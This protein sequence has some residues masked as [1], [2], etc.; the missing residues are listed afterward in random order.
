MIYTC[1]GS[2]YWILKHILSSEERVFF[3]QDTISI[4]NR[5][6]LIYLIYWQSSS[7]WN[8]AFEHEDTIFTHFHCPEKF[9]AHFCTES[10]QLESKCLNTIF[11]NCA[12][13]TCLYRDSKE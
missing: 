6:T 2:E 4:F 13:G 5:N 7:K 10:N 3:L 1:W 12:W 8:G 11:D 9:R